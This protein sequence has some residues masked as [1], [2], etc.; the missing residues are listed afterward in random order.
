MGELFDLIRD[1]NRLLDQGKL[2]ASGAADLLVAWEGIDSVLAFERDAVA[3]P[4][5]VLALVEQRQT[6]RA[7]KQWAESDRLRAAIAALG[8]IVKDTKEGPKLSPKR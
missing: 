3:V 1:S 8:W 5:E 6:A 4:A 2:S 7:N